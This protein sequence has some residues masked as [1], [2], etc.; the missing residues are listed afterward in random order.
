[1]ISELTRE[2]M[3]RFRKIRRSYY[4]LWILG[5]AFFFSLFAGFIAN[6]K[7]LFMRYDG[8]TYFPVVKFYPASGFGGEYGTEPDYAVL[9][10]DPAFIAK[11][12]FMILPPIPHNPL[13]TYLDLADTPPHK[14]SPDHWL[15]TDNS[16]RDVL[17]R[18][19][20]GLRICMGFALL[21]TL[22]ETILGIIIGGIQGYLGGKVD[23]VLQRLIE[24]WSSLPFLYV[25][26]L[27]G[28]TYGTGFF[29][30]LF[31][32]AIFTWITLSY[33]MRGEFF[34]IK[35]QAYVRAARAAGLGH[36]RIFFHHILP[37]SLTP[38]ITL[39]PFSVVAGISSLTAL[40]FLGFGLPP[41][42]PSW[43]E[44]LKQ[45]LDNLHKPW[46]AI[47]SVTA[48]FVTLLL[49]TFIGE[50]VREAFDP[51]SGHHIV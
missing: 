27:L 40:D 16:A 38:V 30:L 23:I 41:P 37:N 7:P 4:S 2:R 45:G 48:L 8:H 28:A 35:G 5:V 14:P 18:L 50:G 15:G 33:Y 9:R 10:K 36:I 26:I 46:I 1:M 21:L 11:G 29:L 19:I 24:I 17:A 13:H 6:D 43:G 12:G 47:S 3:R 42:T 49:T 51:K 25:V 32:M 31:I 44:M 39:M 20:Y 34:K 22:C